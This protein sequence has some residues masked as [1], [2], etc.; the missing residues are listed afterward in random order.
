[1]RLVA[2][3]LRVVSCSFDA[4]LEGS[5]ARSGR[6][7]HGHEAA[8]WHLEP[9]LP[10]TRVLRGWWRR[11]ESNPR[12]PSHRM[13]VYKLRLPLE[14]ARWQVGSRPTAGL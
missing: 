8:R 5:R 2:L 12:P 14:F 3:L 1:V 10:E 13:N 11:R 9:F 7:R 6:L 4:L